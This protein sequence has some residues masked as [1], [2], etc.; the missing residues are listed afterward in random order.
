MLVLIAKRLAAA[1]V[2]LWVVATAVFFA[3]RAAGDPL[4]AILGGPGSQASQETV[5]K[6][7]ADYGLDQPLVIQ[8]GQ[9]L[10][11]IITLQFGDSYARRLPVTDLLG[12]QVP[13]TATLVVTSL[14]TAWVLA[15]GI[16]IAA[17]QLATRSRLGRAGA[18]VLRGLELVSS[19]TPQFWLGAVLISVFAAGL[20]WLPAT[21]AG[22]SAEALILPTLT[23]AIPTA[24]YLGQV[25]R[26]GLASAR[27]A[28]YALTARARGAG[29]TRVLLQH[30]LRPASGP[31]L[32]LT[33][34]AF[35]SLLSGSVVVE[36]LFGRPGLGRAL[37][38]ATSL[39]DVPV[40]IGGVLI[41]AL[42]Y[43]F[44]M[45]VTDL[46]EYWINPAVA[47][48]RAGGQVVAL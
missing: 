20:G 48:A 27:L 12:G 40:V 26:E 31:A 2:V 33:G 16:A 35:G 10:W 43:I 21:S 5:D 42:G 23:L 28:P 8:Y 39:R 25:L 30:C 4:E 1:L 32:A 13:A 45:L 47:R 15:L 29:E 44:I 38:E 17:T 34:W 11:R 37:L 46:L 36:S 22:N 19:V 41:G 14:V 24:G 3:L 7:I 6:A 18:T 9:Q